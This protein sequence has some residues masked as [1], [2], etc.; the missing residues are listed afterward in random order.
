VYLKASVER[1]GLFCFLLGSK[2]AA[3]QY[4]SQTSLLR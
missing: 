3:G 4:T 2:N 1:L